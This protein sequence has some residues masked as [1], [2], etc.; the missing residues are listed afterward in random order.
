MHQQMHNYTVFPCPHCGQQLPGNMPAGV[1]FPCPTCRNA[2]VAPQASAAQM[3]V[4]AAQMQYN[5]QHANTAAAL[6]DAQVTATDPRRAHFSSTS[7]QVLVRDAN[8]RYLIIGSHVDQSQQWCLRALDA[9]RG[10]LVWETPRSFHFTSCPG[11]QQ[12]GSRDGILF[13]FQDSAVY[14]FDAASGQ[15]L[16]QTQ[17][18]GRVQTVAGVPDGDEMDLTYAERVAVVR[19]EDAVR[20]EHIIA[21]DC[22]NGQ[23][24]WHRQ[25]DQKVQ[26]AGTGLLLIKHSDGAEVVQLRTGQPVAEHRGDFGD[27]QV[28]G[29]YVGVKADDYGDDDATGML[30]FDPATGNPVHFVRA[31]S[32]DVGHWDDDAATMLGQLVVAKADAS[33]GGRLIVIDPATPAPKPGFLA[34]LF[35]GGGGGG[36]EG[37]RIAGPKR[38]FGKIRVSTDAICLEVDSWDGDD[39][40]LL[41]LDPN[42]LQVRHDS[43]VFPFEETSSYYEVFANFVAY[44]VPLD[45][46]RN[47]RE[48]RVLETTSGRLLWQRSI[49]HWSSHYF[50]P[51]GLLVV[52]HDTDIDVFNPADGQVVAGYPM[53]R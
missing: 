25:G 21:I 17:I 33:D 18:S 15:M 27:S 48:V 20:N 46:D 47:E 43:G 34:K 14:G 12:M 31:E 40:R 42:T 36:H 51:E 41:V 29:P 35:G 13:L 9:Q 1:Q 38:T 23:L 52:Y 16:W 28:V 45:E 19:T 8:Q 26:I 50:T 11:T 32:I 4:A 24:L 6:H 3:A 2:V 49:G 44:V 37:Q 10:E 30:L 39:N 22:N 7:N 53:P 5:Y